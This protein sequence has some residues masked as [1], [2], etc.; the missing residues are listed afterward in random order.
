MQG[1]ESGD[2][3]DRYLVSWRRTFILLSLR[4]QPGLSAHGAQAHECPT[5]LLVSPTLL[6]AGQHLG[7]HRGHAW[8]CSGCRV[9][10]GSVF[11]FVKTCHEPVVWK[12]SHLQEV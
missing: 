3:W 11:G 1:E 10:L 12:A 2:L 6:Q 7:G 8:C 4:E 9:P 5:L